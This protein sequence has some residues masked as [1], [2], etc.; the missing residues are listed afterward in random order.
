MIDAQFPD[1]LQRLVSDEMSAG[2]YANANEVLTAGVRLLREQREEFERLKAEV[3]VGIDQMERG[4]Y[5]EYND[6]TLAQFFEELK[7]KGRERLAAER[8][9]AS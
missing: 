6:E 9:A 5:R 7:Q 8:E 3:Q 2:N 1:E 4:E